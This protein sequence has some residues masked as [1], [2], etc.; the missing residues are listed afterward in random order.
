MRK[1]IRIVFIAL[2]CAAAYTACQRASEE[3]KEGKRQL[4]VDSLNQTYRSLNDSLTARWE[5]IVADEDQKLADMRRL[6]QEISYFPIYNKARLD[7]LQQQLQQVYEMRFDP[8]TLTSEQIDRYDSAASALKTKI[9][10]FA[11]EH[12]DV[13]QYPLV[14]QLIDSIEAADQRVLFHRVKY[15]NY[16]RDYNAFLETNREFVRK[17]DTTGLHRERTLFQLSE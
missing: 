2:L 14:G 4:S 12:P 3:K 16:A 13:E 11:Q 17:I 10:Q 15:D 5:V 1:T 8:E 7:T 6:L 9:I